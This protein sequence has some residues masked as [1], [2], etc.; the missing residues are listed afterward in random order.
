M[1]NNPKKGKSHITF[2]HWNLNGLMA[3]NF[4]KVSL[5]LTPGITNGYDVICLT[6]T[7]LLF[8]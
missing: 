6:E 2:C 7:F 3:Y 4:I 5:L 8:S 1:L